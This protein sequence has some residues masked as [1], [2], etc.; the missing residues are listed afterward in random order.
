MKTVLKWLGIAVVVVVAFVIIAL[1]ALYIY[2]PGL[3]NSW[4]KPGIA[5]EEIPPGVDTSVV[6]ENV[7]VIPMNKQQILEGQT[8]VIKDG[9]IVKLGTGG[10]IEI[11][12]G[13]HI[14]DGNGRFLIPGLSDMH[15]HWPGSEN[16]LLVYLANGVTTIRTMG[17]SLLRFLNGAT[18]SKPECEWVPAF[19]YGGLRSRMVGGR[20]ILSG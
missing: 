1:A 7:T 8:V 2:E 20:G 4:V 11:P 6:F 5:Q 16:D 19:G 13:A 10:D 12:S 14:V 17:G 18:R 9:R 15:V 3:H